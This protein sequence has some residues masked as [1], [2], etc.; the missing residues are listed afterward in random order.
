MLRFIRNNLCERSDINGKFIYIKNKKQLLFVQF[1]QCR[2]K[3]DELPDKGGEQTNVRS[4]ILC[5]NYV[6]FGF[7]ISDFLFRNL[8]SA[9]RNFKT[10]IFV[11]EYLMAVRKKYGI[12]LYLQSYR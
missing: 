9:I 1:H 4:T 7:W 2:E 3:L 12:S 11:A 6:N 10:A 8:K 5:C